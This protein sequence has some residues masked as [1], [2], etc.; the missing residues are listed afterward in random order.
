MK[1]HE[2][3]EPLI[4][5][6]ENNTNDENASKMEK[7]MRNLFPFFGIKSPERKEIYSS[8]K[9]ENGLIPEIN[10]S[11]IVNWC[12]NKPQREYQYFAMEFLGRSVKTEPKEII[13]LYEYMIVTKSWWDT[14]DF[15]ASNLVGRYFINYPEM[16]NTTTQQWMQ[17]NNI[18]LQRTCL[19][20][21]LK[22]RTDLNTELMGSFISKLSNSNEFFIK[23]AIGWILREHSK[24]NPEFVINYVKDTDMSAFSKREALLWMQKKEI[25]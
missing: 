5:L 6:F 10:K 8:F 17:S 4:S 7:Y 11:E 14:V 3:L 15:I 25:I 12:W 2:Y 20:F 13:Q 23:K 21:Q 24:T 1:T 9:K 22:Y 19:L 18:W 16:I